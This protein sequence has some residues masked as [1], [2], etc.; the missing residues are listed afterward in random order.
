[1][2]PRAIQRS[3]LPLFIL[4]A[5]IFAAAI[6]LVFLVANPFAE[7]GLFDVSG[8]EP[9]QPVRQEPP[10][11][12]AAEPAEE[13]PPREEEPSSPRPESA[14]PAV[15]PTDT[16]DRGSPHTV[17]RGNTLFDLA[18]NYWSDPYLWPLIL[19]ENEERVRDPD[20]LRQGLVLEIPPSPLE[21]GTL[22]PSAVEEVTRAHILAHQRY[23]ELG[24]QSL[25]AGRESGNP[26]AIQRGL[27]RLNKSHWVLYSGLR[28]DPDLL[29][30]AR[31]A[32][33]AEDISVVRSF[34]ERFGPRP[35]ASR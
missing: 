34:M 33:S 16:E 9:A 32:V 27:I 21:D 14:E 15:Q 26:W 18:G 24:T 5:V 29:D 22:P 3:G 7:G 19:H 35:G 10:A 8:R 12:Q 13:P 1:M 28:Y 17:V 25:A 23:K 6:G 2:T 4:A 31:G 11:P 20:F 30:R